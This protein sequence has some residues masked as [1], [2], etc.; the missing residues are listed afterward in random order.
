[1][2]LGIAGAIILAIMLINFLVDPYDR[3]GNN[4][5]GV[6][7]SA[8]RQ[9]KSTQVR[10]FP[11]NALL[12]GDSRMEMMPANRLEH[13]I[14]F[15]AA[16]SGGTAEEAY[17]FL[18]HY[19][20]K[21]EVVVLG[22]GLGQG[23][24]AKL[25][26][27]IFT[28]AGLGEAVENLLSLKTLEYSSRTIINFFQRQPPSFAPDGSA[29]MVT[30]FRLYEREDP[31]YQKYQQDVLKTN[32]T[33]FS[34]NK[35]GQMTFYRKIVALLSERKILCVAVVLPLH[36]ALAAQVQSSPAMADYRAWHAELA[37][38]FTN[39]VDMSYDNYGASTNFFKCDSLHFKPDA[40][41][42]MLN[43][44]AIPK[45]IMAVQQEKLQRPM[46]K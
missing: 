39:V 25:S 34:W 26:G 4:R 15:N 19:A 21:Q 11:H 35:S 6:Y 38:V 23:D 40:G 18:E 13:F 22:V 24:P 28:S 31:A 37:T 7:I 8:A 10:R 9:T 12:M 3:Y 44:E 36:E 2:L 46:K 42:R 41:I 17:Y 20:A 14:F 43:S 27:D 5:L 29:E 30:W 32:L 1:M 16:F 33:S 45:A